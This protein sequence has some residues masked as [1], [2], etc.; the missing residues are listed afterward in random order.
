MLVEQPVMIVFDTDKM[1]F[2]VKP[3][4]NVQ[5]DQWIP[6]GQRSVQQHVYVTL[7]ELPVAA[8]FVWVVASAGENCP[9]IWLPNVDLG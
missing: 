8:M 7:I 5:N 3:Y 4:F 1:S 9:S 6:L 2:M